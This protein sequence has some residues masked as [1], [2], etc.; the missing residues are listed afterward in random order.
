MSILML[1]NELRTKV[2]SLKLVCC[3]SWLSILLVIK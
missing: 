2:D 3:N 1:E